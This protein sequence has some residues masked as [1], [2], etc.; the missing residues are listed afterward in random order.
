[1]DPNDEAVTSPQ[2]QISGTSPISLSPKINWI[3]SVVFLILGI[4][5]G[6]FGFWVCQ[7]Y[8]VKK[9]PVSTESSL[10][11]TPLPPETLVKEGDPTANW[12]T[13]TSS[14]N[15]QVKYPDDWMVGTSST[16]FSIKKDDYKIVFTFPSAFGPGI[17]IFSDSPDFTKNDPNDPIMMG[18]KCPGKYIEIKGEQF[19]FRRKDMSNTSPEGK[20][21]GQWTIYVKDKDG[22]FVTVPPIGYETPISFDSQTILLMDQILS[23]FRFLDALPEKAEG[24][25]CGGI[26]GVVCPDGFKCKYDGDYPD[27]SGTCESLR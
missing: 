6:A 26:A 22:N 14:N 19:I 9:I 11:P 18:S 8:L 4:L 16:G 7:N 24:V 20:Q 1:M 25:F 13:Y 21:N 23:T 5:I 3:I 15:Y 2:P 10:T 27:A 17:C 12:K